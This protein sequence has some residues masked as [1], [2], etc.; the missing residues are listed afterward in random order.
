M[1]HGFRVFFAKSTNKEL[2]RDF[3]IV[4]FWR[5]RCDLPRGFL[6]KA[7]WSAARRELDM[8][9]E[10]GELGLRVLGLWSRMS[11]RTLWFN[12]FLMH[13]E[14]FSFWRSQ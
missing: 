13:K 3:G 6:V 9:R 1:K 5:R 12:Y 8:S 7:R 11:F 14:A 10:T 4:G 2:A